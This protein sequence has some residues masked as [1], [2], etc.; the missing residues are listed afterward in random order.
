MNRQWALIGAIL[1]ASGLTGSS[2]AMATPPL[3]S[4]RVLRRVAQLSRVKLSTLKA[5]LSW[6]QQ[7]SNWVRPVVPSPTLTVILQ[8]ILT[9]TQNYASPTL[10]T[11]P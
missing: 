8:S 9:L 11:R 7:L 6:V 10:V 1:L 3:L 4:R 5:N 2:Y